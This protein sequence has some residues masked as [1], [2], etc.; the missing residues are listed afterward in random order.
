MVGELENKRMSPGFYGVFIL[1][2]EWAIS[3]YWR[4][5][6]ATKF[7]GSDFGISN[8]TPLQVWLVKVVCC[9]VTRIGDRFTSTFQELCASLMAQSSR[10]PDLTDQLNC[11]YGLFGLLEYC[12]TAG[13][14]CGW[15]WPSVACVAWNT[16][17]RLSRGDPFNSA[18]IWLC[19]S[20]LVLQMKALGTYHR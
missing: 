6:F 20:H 2:T 1:F 17:V 15:V 4:F 7:P 10:E 12:E 3:F 11:V 16:V 8:N 13:V 5:L 18:F 19:T 9:F 14:H